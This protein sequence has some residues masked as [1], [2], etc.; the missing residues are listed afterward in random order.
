MLPRR[1]SEADETL[2]R[3][4]IPAEE[5]RHLFTRERW[6]TGFR[7][8]RAPNVVCLEHYLPSPCRSLVNPPILVPPMAELDEVDDDLGANQMAELS[9][10]EFR[11]R[12]AWTIASI[13]DEY[14]QL[15]KEHEPPATVVDRLLCVWGRLT[16]EQRVE[17]LQRALSPQLK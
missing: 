14:R 1:Y 2:L 9:E 12:L 6:S 5:D 11:R 4:L 17:F 10:Q 15:L 8:Y 16:E 13:H 3:T 7:W